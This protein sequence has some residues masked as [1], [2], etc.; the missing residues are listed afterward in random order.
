[1]MDIKKLEFNYILSVS[2]GFSFYLFYLY[3]KE[4]KS[5]VECSLL[6]FTVQNNLIF[7]SFYFFYYYFFFFSI[8]YSI[9]KIVNIRNVTSFLKH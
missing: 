4:N 2:G 3:N 9:I 8:L 1:M 7:N 6:S 5:Y